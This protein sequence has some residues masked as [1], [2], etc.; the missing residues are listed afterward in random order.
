[1][2]HFSLSAIALVVTLLAKNVL[3]GVHGRHMLHHNVQRDVVVEDVWVTETAIEYVTVKWDGNSLH[4]LIPTPG[5]KNAVAQDSPQQGDIQSVHPPLSSVP[6]PAQS[7]TLATAI[8]LPS[9]AAIKVVS[10]PAPVIASLA[11]A[12]VIPSQAPVVAAQLDAVPVPV[13][14]VAPAANVKAVSTRKRGAAYNNAALVKSFTGGSSKVSW[15]YNWGSSTGAIPTDTEYVPMLW[16]TDSVHSSNWNFLASRAIS[17]GSKHLLAFNE[18]D[19]WE[20]SNLSPSDA[21]AGYKTFMQPFAG[22]AKLGAPAVTNGGGSMGLTYLKSFLLSCSGC[23]I[24]F[25]PIHWYD[26]ATNVAYF[27]KHVQ[28]AHAAA[29]G[30][31]IWITEF[32]AAGTLA[33]QT[34]FLKQ[35]LPWLDST[36]YVQRYAYF[37]ADGI[38]TQNNK[39]SALGNTFKSY[40]G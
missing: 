3:A 17:R 34:A 5:A 9:P 6:A 2:M 27:K 28:D 33:Q 4:T 21:A 13:A 36:S 35:V 23:T 8:V 25:V 30:R 24:D 11:P 37:Y 12:E 40:S 32:A 10:S 38:L 39:I 16:G 22:K 20:Q 29:G 18:P 14:F 19:H 15:A 7:T 31:P 1:M 26:S